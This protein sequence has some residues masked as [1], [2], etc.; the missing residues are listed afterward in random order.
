MGAQNNFLAGPHRQ[1]VS[2]HDRL[3]GLKLQPVGQLPVDGN[4]RHLVP[5]DGTHV[6]DVG[7]L[8]YP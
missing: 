3:V 6:P 2:M 1:T 7:L 8:E 4:A 5:V